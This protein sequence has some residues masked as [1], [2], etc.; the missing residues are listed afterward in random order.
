M[1]LTAPIGAFPTDFFG[2]APRA[3]GSNDPPAAQN[4]PARAVA[5][6]GVVKTAPFPFLFQRS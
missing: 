1:V 3:D 6:H 4:G 5:A 2:F